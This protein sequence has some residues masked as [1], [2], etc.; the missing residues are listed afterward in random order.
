MEPETTYTWFVTAVDPDGSG[1]F[2]EEVYNFTT[3]Y[4]NPP[5]TPIIPSGLT[6]VE[7]GAVSLYETSAMDPD[8]HQVQY[9]LT[10]AMNNI[11]IGH[12]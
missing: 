6:D 5:N 4:N 1:G 12:H 10:G 7:A 11:V 2:T 8:G 3:E 9:R